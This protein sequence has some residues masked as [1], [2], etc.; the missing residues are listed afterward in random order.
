MV[1]Y[2]MIQYNMIE[3]ERTECDIITLIGNETI[4]Y[5]IHNG[6]FNMKQCDA[7]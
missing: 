6:F 7:V 4:Q 2:H 3:Y 5:N 1:L